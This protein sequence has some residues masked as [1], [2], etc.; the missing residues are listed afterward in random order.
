MSTTC[1]EALF[2]IIVDSLLDYEPQLSPPLVSSLQKSSFDL[3]KLLGLALSHPPS[4]VE[5]LPFI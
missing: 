3:P 1:V 4:N 2:H 5:E